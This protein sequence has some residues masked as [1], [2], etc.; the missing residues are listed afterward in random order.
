MGRA[1]SGPDPSPTLCQ[2]EP[3]RPQS[4][5]EQGARQVLNPEGLFLNCL[6]SNGVSAGPLRLDP[7]LPWE[8]SPPGAFSFAVTNPRPR[9]KIR[10]SPE[11]GGSGIKGRPLPQPRKQLR[12]E[13]SA[14][15][16]AAKP[17]DLGCAHRLGAPGQWYLPGL[18]LGTVA[19]FAPD[20]FGESATSRLVHASQ[21]RLATTGAML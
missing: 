12:S 14:P 10:E 13:Q 16:R 3:A 19:P 2:A 21:L 1:G 17:V 20:S 18:A 6:R 11:P 15:R 5:T 4:G 8:R 7:P 9:W